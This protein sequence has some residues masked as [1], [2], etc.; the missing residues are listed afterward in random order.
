MP[1]YLLFVVYA[2]ATSKLLHQTALCRLFECYLHSMSTDLEQPASRLH[3]QYA[4]NVFAHFFSGCSSKG[5]DW[6]AWEFR[7][8]TVKVTGS[9]FIYHGAIHQL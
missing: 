1:Q 3:A 6:H 9:A 8:H 2:E 5:H 7:L 4:K